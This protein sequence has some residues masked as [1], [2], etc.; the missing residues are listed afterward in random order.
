M[1]VVCVTLYETGL[2]Y[3]TWNYALPCNGVM[4]TAI[5]VPFCSD[6]KEL[7]YNMT[8]NYELPRNGV[9]LTAVGVIF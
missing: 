1:C 9:M 2:I 3:M 6:D 8:C 7:E 4:L 5:G